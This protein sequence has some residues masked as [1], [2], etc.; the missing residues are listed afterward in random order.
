MQWAGHAWR[1]D[2]YLIKEIIT[3]T[4]AGRRPRERPRRR[5]IDSVNEIWMTIA[6]ESGADW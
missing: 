3:W 2:R 4:L 1:A 6:Q 5:L